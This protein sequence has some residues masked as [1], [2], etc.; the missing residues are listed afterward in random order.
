MDGRSR[1]LSISPEAGRP[2]GYQAAASR[3]R[4]QAVGPAS[5]HGVADKHSSRVIVGR[6]GSAHQVAPPWNRGEA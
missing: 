1:Q 4:R 6:L 5:S 3:L 2:R